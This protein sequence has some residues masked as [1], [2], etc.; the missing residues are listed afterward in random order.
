[1]SYEEKNWKEVSG[2]SD[3]LWEYKEEGDSIEGELVAKKDG[4]GANNSKMYDIKNIETGKVLGIWGCTILDAKMS[5]ME[6]GDSVRVMYKGTIPNKVAG[7]N[8]SK[9]FL[10]AKYELNE[11]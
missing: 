11:G 6:V 4:V 3:G 10:V 2:Q 8:A 5:Q 9:N 7:R 1:M